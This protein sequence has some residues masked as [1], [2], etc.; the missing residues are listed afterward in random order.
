[1]NDIEDEDHKLLWH[2]N[3]F[4]ML[5]RHWDK[6]DN[7]RI[8]K[9]LMLIR[10]QIIVLFKHIQNIWDD[11]PDYVPQY[12]EAV[13]EESLKED[14]VPMGIGLQMA[15][16]Y[17]EEMANNLTEKLTQ[18]RIA[19]LLDP[20]L[21]ALGQTH[22]IALFQRIKEKVFEKL[23]E[24][25]GVKS[26]ETNSLYFTKFDIVEYAENQMFEVASSSD[27]I[28]SRRNEIYKLYEKAAGREEYKPPPLPYR[29]RLK[30]MMV[31]N[32]PKTKHQRRN[33]LRSQVQRAV[34]IKKRI[35]EM[36][37][38]K[39]QLINDLDTGNDLNAIVDNLNDTV[40]NPQDQSQVSYKALL[41]KINEKYQ[42]NPEGK[43]KNFV[44]SNYIFAFR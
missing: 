21:K 5:A 30:M 32:K 22:Q 41:N 20:F 42:N 7:W 27:T 24:S 4:K 28:E 25:N 11:K 35:L 44:E 23:I 36:A 31:K 26:S 15:D 9:Y 13:Y 8:N 1:M 17:I 40:D 19:I 14:D 39:L 10:K 37:N 38:E 33:I 43:P 6:L 3:F 12:M 18:S 2:R 16:V 29:Q 34:K